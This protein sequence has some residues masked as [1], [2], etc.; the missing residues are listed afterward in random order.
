MEANDMIKTLKLPISALIIYVSMFT[1]LF[2]SPFLIE[3]G[4]GL[5][6]GHYLSLLVAVPV[7]ALSQS[8]TLAPVLFSLYM[9]LVSTVINASEA[10][11]SVWIF[12]SLHLVAIGL[13]SSVKIEIAVKFSKFA[14]SAYVATILFTQ[15]LLIFGMGELVSRLSVV[16]SDNSG[17]YRI[18]AYATEP[19]FAGIMLL[20]LARFLIF[21]DPDWVSVRRFYSI[22][23]AMILLNSLFAILSAILLSVMHLNKFRDIRTVFIGLLSCFI[24]SISYF[25]F[26][27]YAE[28]VQNLDFSNSMMGLGS[29]S[30][31]LLPY[32]YLFN[33][34]PKADFAFVLLWGAGADVFQSNF[35]S[36]IGQFYTNHDQLSGHTAAMIY[37][38]GLPAVIPW[39]FWNRPRG[40]ID[41]FLFLIMTVLILLNT[42]IGS[43]LF[44]IF[45]IYS[46]AEQRSRQR[47]G[48]SV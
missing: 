39:I 18:S 42:G 24:M 43:Y 48:S 11:V 23:L 27:D 28:R 45:G 20:I 16:I 10:S 30:I 4:R 25:Y 47:K 26:G 12:H 5:I 2:P 21:H 22:L 34:L 37:N 40:F 7:L 31:R 19:A 44:L 35:F 36:D 9:L 14:I 8:I 29:G 46:I 17:N 1:L 41:R 32:S 38:Y 13:L 3:S 6:F 15:L 33:E